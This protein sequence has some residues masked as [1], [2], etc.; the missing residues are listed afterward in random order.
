MTAQLVAAITATAVPA[1]AV[2]LWWTG[3]GSFIFKGSDGAVLAVDP[4]LSDAG[5]HRANPTP[6]QFPP[7]LTPQELA[8]VSTAILATHE[9]LD[10][11]DPEATP[12]FVAANPRLRFIGPRG[13]RAKWATLGVPETQ[14]DAFDV[15]ESRPF[16]A[17]TLH[18]VF[19][20]HPHTDGAI[21]VVLDTGTTRIYHSGDTEAHPRLAEV[22]PFA[23][24]L[25]TIVIN[26][27]G[28]NMHADDAARTVAMLG[29]R[30]AIPTHYDLFATNLADPQEFVRA[31]AR[32]APDAR[33]LVLP[34]GELL[35]WTG[36]T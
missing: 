27:R 25:A 24:D 17:W 18:A 4:Y 21:G 2:A 26:G 19:A 16:G 36:T 9:H 11:V 3:Q 34:R 6:R 20:D 28:G 7:P 15:G 32:E 35:L 8:A 12:E 14:M 29:T 30:T 23:P 22:R 10:H 33:A 5:A 31:L 13:V 1:G